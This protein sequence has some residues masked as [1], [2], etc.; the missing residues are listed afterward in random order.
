M[1]LRCGERLIFRAEEKSV[2]PP[3]SISPVAISR[4]PA[5]ASSRVVFPEPEGPKIAV[6][7]ASKE[8]T[9]MSSKVA[10]G[11]RQLRRMLFFSPRAEQPLGAPDEEKRERDG[12]SQE[13]VSF[14]IFPELNVVVDRQRQSLSFT[15]NISRQQD[16]RAEFTERTGKR[17]QCAGDDAFVGERYGDDEKN[18]QGRRAESGG[19]LLKPRGDLGKGSAH[20]ANQQ[21]KG[22]YRHGNQHAFPVEDD[23][24][25]AVVKPLPERTAPAEDFQ[26]DQS[27][28]HRRHHQRQKHDGLDHAFERPF[29]AREEPCQRDAERQ[30]QQRA[31]KPDRDRE[32]RD[33]PGVEG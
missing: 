18:S 8:E 15:G 10:S 13:R 19:D 28:R 27:G 9:T 11:M 12:D 25:T 22:N 29:L 33:F 7:R 23:F 2:L 32:K 31:G 14:G 24:Y 1:F 16:S 21:R 20:G 5:T 3:I 4:K 26:Q 6:T 30:D 17:Q